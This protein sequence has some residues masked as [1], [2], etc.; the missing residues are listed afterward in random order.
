[1]GN[2]KVIKPDNIKITQFIEK[3]IL[4]HGHKYNYDSVVYVNNKQKVIIECPIHGHFLQTPYHH[5]HS[6]GCVKCANI[7]RAKNKTNSYENFIEYAKKTHG[8]KY[9]YHHSNY[10]DSSKKVEIYCSEHGSFFQTPKAHLSGQGCYSCGNKRKSEKA[11]IGID[12]FLYRSKR[13]HVDKYNYSLINEFTTL[14]K[15]YQIICPIHGVFTQLGKN[16]IK[17]IG[18]PTCC[19][20]KG[21][22]M[23][24]KFLKMNDIKF[25]RQVK[26]NYHLIFIYL[27]I[28]F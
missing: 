9:R 1:V 21:E 26:I 3:S 2:V 15:Y 18:C 16:H 10:I 4:L 22:I 7:I 28:K 5:T 8:D 14:D 24:M 12:L 6:L 23:I 11:M 17:G 13:I 27:M 25:E 19:E 20:S